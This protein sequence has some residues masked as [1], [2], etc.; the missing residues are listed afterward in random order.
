MARPACVAS[1]GVH[2]LNKH[3]TP[4]F[5]CKLSSI[6]SASFSVRRCSSS[7][8][9]YKIDHSGFVNPLESNPPRNDQLGI[10]EVATNRNPRALEHLNVARRREG[11]NFQAP[12][13]SFK[14]KLVLGMDGRYVVAHVEH[15]SG[16]KVVWAS[17]QEHALMKRL[18]SLTDITAV[19]AVARLL[20][21]RCLKAGLHHL[22]VEDSSESQRLSVFLETLSAAGI[23][24]EEPEVVLPPQRLGVNYDVVNPDLYVDEEGKSRVFPQSKEEFDPEIDLSFDDEG[25]TRKHQF[26]VRTWE[27]YRPL[28]DP[29]PVNYAAALKSLAAPAAADVE[30]EFVVRKGG[31]IE[32]VIE[33]E[34]KQLE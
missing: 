10:R 13:R 25:L 26:P 33:P 14:N 29:E 15:S 30:E 4:A 21:R 19:K 8:T 28:V 31:E 22:A 23:G 6:L 24:L 7:E 11:W 9:V 17:S 20:A 3:S 16:D 32:A 5:L 1:L 12:K 27:D 34:V 2:F 18:Y